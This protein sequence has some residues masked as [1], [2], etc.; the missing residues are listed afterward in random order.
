MFVSNQHGFLPNRSTT[1]AISDSLNYIIEQID[2][3]NLVSGIY[4]DLSKA[5][6]LIDH[7]LLLIKLEHYGVRGKSLDLIK[8]YLTNRY[9]KVC[10]KSVINNKATEIF[11]TP[12]Q[13]T[14][15]VPQGSILGPL[16]FLIFVNDL[17]SVLNLNSLYQFADDTSCIISQT[18]IHKLSVETS[19][20]AKKN[21]RLV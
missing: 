15:G 20:I 9:Q 16:L 18:S 12:T 4:F 21:G 7:D 2:N 19:D 8:S 14:Q 13:I 6:D 17:N 11:S 3:N 5:F 10:I 1:T